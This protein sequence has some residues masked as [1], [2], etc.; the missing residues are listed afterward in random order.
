MRLKSRSDFMNLAVGFNPREAIGKN[1]S[2][3][4]QM[5]ESI[6]ADA[7]KRRLYRIRAMHSAKISWSL[8]DKASNQTDACLLI[9]FCQFQST[10]IVRNFFKIS[11]L[12]IIKM[13]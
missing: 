13:V 10:R 4:R 2:L 11:T 8:R 12:C 5:N 9:E 1:V 7:T 6:V 3:Q